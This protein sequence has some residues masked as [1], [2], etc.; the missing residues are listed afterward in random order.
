MQPYH[1]DHLYCKAPATKEQLRQWFEEGKKDG[2]KCVMHCHDVAKN[3]DVMVSLDPWLT[4]DDARRL[5]QK[6]KGRFVIIKFFYTH[7]P[8]DEQWDS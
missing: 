3:E 2:H 1:P 6:G 7:L 5:E 8:F 4:P